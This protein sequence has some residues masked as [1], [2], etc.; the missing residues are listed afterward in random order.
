MTK[1]SELKEGDVILIN[2]PMEVS[3]D[4]VALNDKGEHEIY[5]NIPSGAG[6]AT[7]SPDENVERVESQ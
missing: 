2:V 6:V 5:F 7:L 4:G 3:I 1:P